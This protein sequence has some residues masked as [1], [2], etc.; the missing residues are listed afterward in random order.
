MRGT[1]RSPEGEGILGAYDALQHTLIDV[2]P[3][4]PPGR[5]NGTY[6]Q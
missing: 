5:Y 4:P 1:C 6:V 3:P 2:E